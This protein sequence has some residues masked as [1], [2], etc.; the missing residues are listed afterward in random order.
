MFRRCYHRHHHG[1]R[2]S[3]LTEARE[4]CMSASLSETTNASFQATLP[5]C[6]SLNSAHYMQYVDKV[7][8]SLRRNPK[9]FWNFVN[10]KR[11]QNDSV[12]ATIFFNDD[13]T[14]IASEKCN[15]FAKQF[16]SVFNVD[17]A[18][19]DDATIAT[20]A[21]PDSYCNID[22]PFVT[23]EM[24]RKAVT[25]KSSTAPGPDRIPAI[26]LKN[27]TDVLAIPLCKIFNLSLQQKK[28]PE[29]WKQSFM[30]PVYKNGDKRDVRNYRGITLLCAGSK[31]FE[32]IM[33]DCL[34]SQ[35]KMYISTD[36]HGF[37]PSRSVT[38]NL[39][40]F[41]SDC[42]NHLENGKQWKWM[43]FTQI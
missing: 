27:C 32:T 14:S 37:Y 28:F 26:V 4:K 36:Q 22:V 30:F 9:R 2:T 5:N 15:L 34:F 24:L 10:S 33:N 12:P 40:S 16:T 39:L 41:T 42:I 18:P 13:V 1:E 6:K 35:T 29:L 31:L 21:V 25:L 7:Q 17:R 19:P 3:S 11:K 43:Q 20:A 38:T 8:N 23:E